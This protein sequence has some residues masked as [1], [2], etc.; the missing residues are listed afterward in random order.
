MRNKETFKKD[1][2]KVLKPEFKAELSVVEDAAFV[3]D[4]TGEL[5]YNIPKTFTS[6]GKTESFEFKKE[7]RPK[8]DNPE[9]GIEDYFYVGRVK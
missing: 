1:A 2:E 6:T 8:T 7:L 3:M 4:H 5:M 9:E